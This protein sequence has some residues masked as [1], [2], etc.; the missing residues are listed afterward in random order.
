MVRKENQVALWQS[1]K[2][3]C[4]SQG[5]MPWDSQTGTRLE[6]ATVAP[7]CASVPMD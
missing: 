7:L 4:R 5:R 6:S 2:L 1:N 3:I